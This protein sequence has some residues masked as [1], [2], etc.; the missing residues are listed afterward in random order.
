M[1]QTE[2][3]VRCTPPTQGLCDNSAGEA[4]S[5]PQQ[6]TA[7]LSE[8]R[9]HLGGRGTVWNLLT[10]S[11]LAVMCSSCNQEFVYYF[12]VQLPCP[13][14]GLVWNEA[15]LILSGSIYVLR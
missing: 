10:E 3:I 7:S 11:F 1:V 9:L 4:V 14:F 15:E 8:V 5:V 12:W 13:R 6:P 2:A